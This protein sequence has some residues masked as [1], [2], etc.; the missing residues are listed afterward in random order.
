M[1][2]VCM[3]KDFNHSLQKNNSKRKCYENVPCDQDLHKDFPV[4]MVTE[5]QK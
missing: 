3:I 1:E 2:S 4:E 5:Q